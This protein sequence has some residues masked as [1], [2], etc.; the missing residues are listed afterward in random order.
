MQHIASMERL[1]EKENYKFQIPVIQ[2][3]IEDKE[4]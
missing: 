2:K 3:A 1:G 4:I